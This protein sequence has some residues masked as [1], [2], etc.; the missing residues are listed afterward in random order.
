MR[1]AGATTSDANHVDDRYCGSSTKSQS[2]PLE[3]LLNNLRTVNAGAAVNRGASEQAYAAFP[4]ESRRR[5]HRLNVVVAHS[6]P[7]WVPL[8]LAVA[9]IGQLWI[10]LSSAV[11]PPDSS[12]LASSATVEGMTMPQTA[13]APRRGALSISTEGVAVPV[14]V[15]GI[16]RGLSPVTVSD[17]EP[18]EHEVVLILRNAKVNRRVR[19]EAGATAMLAIA[20]PAVS[21][22]TSGWVR[23]DAKE[24]LQIRESGKLI[25]TTEIERLMLP[26]GEHTLEFVNDEL[27]FVD[28]RVIRVTAGDVSTV[29]VNLPEVPLDINAEPWADVWLDGVSLGATPIG[30][31]STTIG[32]HELSFRHPQFGE[33]QRSI[34]VTLKQPARIGVDLRRNE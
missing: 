19:V 21:G 11:Q 22:A 24:P 15:D 20:T 34:V 13:Q 12:Q 16:N 26:S 18:G 17:L 5:G 6:M 23:V 29:T 30:A 7:N 9:V 32:R 25:G 3:G 14:V 4:R 31:V 28:R 8:V 27:G 2:D 1:N 10:I 33:R